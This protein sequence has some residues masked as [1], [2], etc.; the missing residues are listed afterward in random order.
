MGKLFLH[1]TKGLLENV[2]AYAHMCV[3][4]CGGPKVVS[5]PIAPRPK[6]ERERF[7]MSDTYALSAP[8]RSCLRLH[9]P[10]FRAGPFEYRRDNPA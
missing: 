8:A 7:E 9:R 6:I 1:S 5:P 2:C 3:F 10:P 4:V